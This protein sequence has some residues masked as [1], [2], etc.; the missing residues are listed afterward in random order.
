VEPIP[1]SREAILELD[2]AV[3][4][5]DLL[6]RLSAVGA[7][8]RQLVPDCLGMSL[9][10]VENDLV[11][12]LV[13]TDPEIAL[14]DAMQYLSDG[15]CLEGIR[16]GEVLELN[17]EQVMDEDEWRLFALASA[18]SAVRSTLTLPIVVDGTVTGSV[19]LY[20]ASGH[21][22]T[23]LHEQLAEIVGGWAPGAVAN[24]DLSFST[25]KLAEDAPKRLRERARFDTA[26][27]LL[28]AREE[29][30]VDVARERLIGSAERAG[31]SLSR[32]AQAVITYYSRD[33]HGDDDGR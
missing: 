14:L 6:E 13:A 8:V 7:R 19:N 4:D 22:F 10:M 21:A 23:G 24:A 25:R 9:S 3:A 32:I 15:P 5:D 12:T 33:E 17:D 11:L 31:V 18:E 28:A 26:V 30:S 16:T 2:P 20:G 29:L 1:E 27:G